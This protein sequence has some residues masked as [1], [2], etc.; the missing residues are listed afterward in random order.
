LLEISRLRAKSVD[1]DHILRATEASTLSDR[2]CSTAAG[3][4]T[5]YTLRQKV[6]LKHLP[7]LK[8][9]YS[10]YRE[11]VHPHATI[12][13]VYSNVYCK[14]CLKS[15]FLRVAKDESLFPPTCYHQ[16]IDIST[17]KADFSVEEL[18]TYRSAKLEFTS[19][20]RVY[21]ASSKCAKFI[22]IQQQTADYA[23]YKSYSAR[24][25]MYCKVLA[26]NG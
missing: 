25:C 9:E 18:T 24:T 23:S 2:S 26:H 4:S 22:P 1:W 12:R 3:P 11:A 7:Q 19:T 14:L 13:L 15:F 10:V 21:Y 16:A 6:V 5:Y 20:D 17:I 8:V